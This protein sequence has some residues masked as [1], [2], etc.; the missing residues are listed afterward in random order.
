M[1]VRFKTRD[2]PVAGTLCAALACAGAR[3]DL[4][5]PASTLGGLLPATRVGR[6][7]HRGGTARVPPHHRASVERAV[8]APRTDKRVVQ[9][10]SRYEFVC[11]CSAGGAATPVLT[12][13]LGARSGCFSSW[14]A[15]TI[16]SLH[17]WLLSL[18]YAVFS[19]QC[20]EQKSCLPT[21]LQYYYILPVSVLH[22]LKAH[23]C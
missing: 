2:G 12:G 4:T 13:V 20:T 10:I 11:F 9:Y 15:S 18:S 19:S 1:L 14:Y 5:S 7:A 16:L 6:Q 23:L 8:F 17:H 21:L 22:G 3:R